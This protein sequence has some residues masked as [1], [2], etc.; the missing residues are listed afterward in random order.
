M[1]RLLISGLS[2]AMLC[3]CAAWAETAAE[4]ADKNADTLAK[5]NDQTIAETSFL[6]QTS[7]IMMNAAHNT[8]FA[9][10]VKRQRILAS[11]RTRMAFTSFFF[12]FSVNFF[13][14]RLPASIGLH[15]VSRHFLKIFTKYIAL[16]VYNI[17]MQVVLAIGSLWAVGNC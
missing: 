12:I 5:V 15:K 4:W 1:K 8:R 7:I 11:G 16:H 14:T 3:G 17:V 6:S 13:Q 10:F 9:V 2:L